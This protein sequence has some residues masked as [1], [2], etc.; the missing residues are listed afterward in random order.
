MLIYIYE[1]MKALDSLSKKD[2]EKHKHSVDFKLNKV[3][4]VSLK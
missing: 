4:F 2:N 3:Y 1:Y